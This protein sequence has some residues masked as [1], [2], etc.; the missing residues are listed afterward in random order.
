[1]EEKCHNLIFEIEMVWTR[2]SFIFTLKKKTKTKN[3]LTFKF[4]PLQS[5]KSKKSPVT[6][7]N[8]SDQFGILK[9]FF[10]FLLKGKRGP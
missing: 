8:P 2:D 1:M 10:F 9:D 6:M 3:K 5:P 4:C 7:S